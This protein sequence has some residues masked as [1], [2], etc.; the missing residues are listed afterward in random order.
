M[1][2]I[3]DV[4]ILRQSTQV[5]LR[6]LPGQLALVFPA[7]LTDAD[8]QNAL[9]TVGKVFKAALRHE[10]R[11]AKFEARA[12]RLLRAGKTT[13]G[14]AM[15]ADERSHVWRRASQTYAYRREDGAWVDAWVRADQQFREQRIDG[16]SGHARGISQG[17]ERAKALRRPH[18]QHGARDPGR[19]REVIA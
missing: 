14:R 2:D 1:P 17:S 7:D 9:D 11:R 12:L 13:A 6:D 10:E 3:A 19:A 4:R 15:L 18:R 8:L 16:R 5:D